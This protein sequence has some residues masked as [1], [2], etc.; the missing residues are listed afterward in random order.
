MT[1]HWKNIKGAIFDVDGTL[2]D[3]MPIWENLGERYLAGLG[4]AAE[5][6]LTGILNTMSTR[7][8]AE[9]LI[10]HYRLKES[11]EETMDG[12]NRLLL[13]FYSLS[14]PLKVGVQECLVMLGGRNITL[15]AATSSERPNVEAAMERLDIR[16]Y[17]QEILTCSEMHTDK[18]QPDIF[19]AAAE[20][21]HTQPEETLVFEDAYHAVQTAKA[22]GFLTIALYDRSSE[23]QEREIRRIS[24]GYFRT[25]E[26]FN[27]RFRKEIQR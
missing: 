3:S 20:K 22:A 2:L 12:I 14:A 24:D 4:I 10:R 16:G 9:Y 6:G 26:D 18:T 25:M 8:G 11:M 5:P 15:T 27:E 13:Q 23:A 21:M 17:F 7:Q 1:Q 19:L